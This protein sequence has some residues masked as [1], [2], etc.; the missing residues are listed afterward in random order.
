L[1]PLS[2]LLTVR[3]C[4][5]CYLA[6]LTLTSADL[7]NVYLNSAK[8]AGT[9]LAGATL[10]GASAAGADLTGGTLQDATLRNA[11]LS[12]ANLTNAN[13]QGADLAGATLDNANLTNANLTGAI[14]T[15]GSINGATV[16]AADFTNVDATRARLGLDFTSIK[17]FVGMK[18]TGANV[19][20]V[21]DGLDLRALAFEG[22]TLG[23][24]FLG[25]NFKGADL[26]NV[27]FNGGNQSAG[28]NFQNAE[29]T[30][31]QI[32][33]QVSSGTVDF[34]G[35]NLRGARFENMIVH[36][37]TVNFGDLQGSQFVN[38]KFTRGD[39]NYPPAIDHITV[40][41]LGNFV[42]ATMSGG[43]MDALDWGGADVSGATFEG[44]EFN[45]YGFSHATGAPVHAELAT[46]RGVS[47][48]DG[49]YIG[50]TS[51]GTCAG[52]FSYY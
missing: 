50:S 1:T 9:N 30:G 33:L 47:C 15:D 29:M 51:A 46:W 11:D 41:H 38:C 37:G 19:Y 16:A 4:A 35:A 13:L 3:G 8:L 26:K 39:G 42:G 36:G 34:R 12:N 17:S 18:F 5:G 14:L 22:A 25:T 52:H 24:S 32:N 23:G 27:V 20:G 10:T 21:F 28:V 2:L 43:M 31:A 49:T 40:V 45:L 6:G 48:P 44:I 7:T